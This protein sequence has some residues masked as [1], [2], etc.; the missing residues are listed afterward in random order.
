MDALDAAIA[1]GD[2]IN[3]LGSHFMLDLET[4]AYGATLGF[5]G[6]DFYISGRCGVLGDV[7]AS[8][9]TAAMV[10]LSPAMVAESWARSATVLPR[11]EAAQEFAS[12]AHRWAEAKL[13]DDVP[14]DRL[15]ELA[16]RLGD[17]ASVAAAPLFAG[18]RELPEPSSPPALAIHRLNALR[19]LRGAMHGAAVLTHGIHP[20][21]A[22]A[23]RTPYML[24]VFGWQPP[25]PEKDPVREPWAAAQA[26]TD[27]AVAAPYEALAPAERAELVELVNAVQAAVTGG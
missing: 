21:A 24:E 10:F 11:R 6:I 23:R 4:Y 20:H 16:G 5:E 14:L 18:W 15:S 3:G 2:A 25:H 19:E 22:V 26:A 27:R 9:A 7:P 13:P 12:V 1:S 8:V 17:A